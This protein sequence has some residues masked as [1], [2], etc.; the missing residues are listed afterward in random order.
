MIV[1]IQESCF[2]QPSRRSTVQSTIRPDDENFSFGPSSMSRSFE[3]FQLAFVQTSQ[4]HVQ[5]P[6]NVRSAMRF[7]SKTQIWEDSGKVQPFRRQSS[8]SRHSS[9]IYG[10]CVHQINCSEKDVMNLTHQALI[11]KLGAAKV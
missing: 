6:F 4:Q 3:L 10:N 2:M 7:L 5:M 11:W 8:W 1:F 9:F